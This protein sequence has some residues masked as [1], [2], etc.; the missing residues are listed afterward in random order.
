MGPPPGKRGPDLNE[1]FDGPLL[2]NIGRFYDQNDDRPPAAVALVDVGLK[3]SG[4]A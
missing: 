4:G 3:L 1:R 2:I